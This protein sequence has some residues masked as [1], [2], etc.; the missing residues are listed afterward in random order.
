VVP[1][2]DP[3]L[4]GALATVAAIT[5]ALQAAVGLTPLNDSSDIRRRMAASS[6]GLS[7]YDRAK[8]DAES[9]LRADVLLNLPALSVNGAVLASWCGLGILHARWVLWL[10]WAAVVLAAIFLFVCAAIGSWSLARAHKQN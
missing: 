6:P 9:R 2:V 7:A 10:P 8:T 3:S 1:S 5:T 4:Y